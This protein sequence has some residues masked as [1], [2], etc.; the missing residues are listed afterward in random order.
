LKKLVGENCEDPDAAFAELFIEKPQ[1][2]ARLLRY[3]TTIE[4][5]YYRALNKLEKLQKER[6]K[7]EQESDMIRAWA[8]SAAAPPLAIGF[9]S[10][11]TRTTAAQPL[12][13][14]QTGR[15]LDARGSSTAPKDWAER[16]ER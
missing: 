15:K 4:R 13:T 12:Q 2:V 8:R 5:A 11:N 16:M 1:E 6:A 10:Q 14:G 7:E 3:V 9:V